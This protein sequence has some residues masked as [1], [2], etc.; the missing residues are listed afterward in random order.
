[1]SGLFVP[2]SRPRL[3]GNNPSRG[4]AAVWLLGRPPGL[5]RIEEALGLD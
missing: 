2:D 4:T 5:Y 1:M 3:A